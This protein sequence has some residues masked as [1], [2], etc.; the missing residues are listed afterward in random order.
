MS[1]TFDELSGLI[2]D[3]RYRVYE[4]ASYCEKCGQNAFSEDETD[5]G[6]ALNCLRSAQAIFVYS[7]YS[8]TI[9]DASDNTDNDEV[10]SNL[11]KALKDKG[12]IEESDYK[13]L[14]VI[15]RDGNFGAHPESWQ[16]KENTKRKENVLQTAYILDRLRKFYYIIASYYKANGLLDKFP[17]YMD[18]QQSLPAEKLLQELKKLTSIDMVSIDKKTE[19]VKTGAVGRVGNISGKDSK[20][21]D[22]KLVL[23]AKLVPNVDK[24]GHP[25]LE[26][27]ID[28]CDQ[29]ERLLFRWGILNPGEVKPYFFLPPI[30]KAAIPHKGFFR[31]ESKEKC[32]GKV[33]VCRISCIDYEN[34]ID[35]SYGPVTNRDIELHHAGNSA[36]SAKKQNLEG[37]SHADLVEAQSGNTLDSAVPVESDDAYICPKRHF[38][39]EFAHLYEEYIYPVEW[40]KELVPEMF[41]DTRLIHYFVRPNDSFVLNSLEKI[42][43]SEYLYRLLRF[44][45]FEYIYFVE[46]AGDS[47]IINVY[48]RASAEHFPKEQ[49]RFASSDTICFSSESELAAALSNVL[50]DTRK[51]TAVVIPLDTIHMEWFSSDTVISLLNRP[52]SNGNLQN[53]LVFTLENENELKSCYVGKQQRLHEWTKTVSPENAVEELRKQH[54]LVLATTY[55]VDEISNLILRK[56]VIENSSVLA[57]VNVSNVYAIAAVIKNYYYSDEEH[58]KAFGFKNQVGYKENLINFL[59]EELEKSQFARQVSIIH[60]KSDLHQ[61]LTLLY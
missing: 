8:I 4:I 52:K 18:P 51:R 24:D 6:S 32:V 57:S 53:A 2:K 16:K 30:N 7:I 27:E 15:R 25:G 29:K 35:I 43:P 11:S 31:F 26:A 60:L 44:Y 20:K 39:L 49:S 37:E 12:I 38:N 33:Y 14:A 9:S 17:M 1:T 42:G 19:D 45:R 61:V 54:R 10:I 41:K 56:K 55:H 58:K 5:R 22:R 34:E 40:T 48:D 28:S 46:A 21:T 13:Q 50:L 47:C 59:D 36:G 23:N 3:D